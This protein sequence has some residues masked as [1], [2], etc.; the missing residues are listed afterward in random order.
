[1]PENSQEQLL[2]QE[3]EVQYGSRTLK[4]HIKRRERKTLAIEVHPD[5][6]IHVVAPDL[7]G[8]DE[9]K[10]RLVK[11]GRWILQQQDYFEQFLPRSPLR[12]YVSGESHY[13][14]GKQYILRI[15]QAYQLEEVKL[16]GGELLI[17][18]GDTSDTNKV[19]CLLMVWY[20][21]HAKRKFDTL[22]KQSIP[23]FKRFSIS[24]KPPLIVKR[25]SKRW[26][27]CTPKGRIVLNPEII[28]AP[29]KCI[30]YVIIHELC[31]LVHPNH[32]KAFFQLQSQLMPDWERWKIKLEK[33]LS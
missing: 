26:G 11:R 4:F 18:V 19:K 1:M 5:T 21:K 23:K 17:F 13:Y 10:S 3:E 27:S 20:Y 33:L 28:K 14:L 9:I 12:E 29:S 2:M 30:E 22:I 6:Q 16:K 31:H 8:L 25:M 32:S 24:E 7:L 15:K